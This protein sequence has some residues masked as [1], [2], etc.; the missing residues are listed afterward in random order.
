VGALAQGDDAEVD[1]A[2]GRDFGAVAV[3]R[4]A[5]PGAVEGD[6][7]DAEVGR[8][9]ELDGELVFPRRGGGQLDDDVTL[10]FRPAK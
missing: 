5:D 4:L 8:P 10:F 7:D 1:L 2:G 9:G 3:E 6:F